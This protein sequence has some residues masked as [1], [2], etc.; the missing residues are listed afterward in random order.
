MGATG[1][2][3]FCPPSDC[4][5]AARRKLRNRRPIFPGAVPEPDT[6]LTEKV[7]ERVSEMRPTEEVSS[8]RRPDDL[9]PTLSLCSTTTI[10]G[11]VVH[12]RHERNPRSARGERRVVKMH[13]LSRKR[14]RGL[15]PAPPRRRF[16]LV[17]L[18]PRRSRVVQF[19]LP[20]FLPWQLRACA[21]GMKN[22]KGPSAPSLLFFPAARIIFRG[23]F[24]VGGG[25]F[26]LPFARALLLC[27]ATR[28]GLPRRWLTESGA[29]TFGPS[30]PSSSCP[31]PAAT[32]AAMS[33]YY[34]WIMAFV[35]S[36]HFARTSE[37]EGKDRREQLRLID[38]PLR[39]RMWPL[40]AFLPSFATRI[41]ISRLARSALTLSRELHTAPLLSSPLCAHSLE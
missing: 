21:V 5:T 25:V 16:L 28:P 40:H 20:S 10:V 32:A 37:E 27:V 9:L 36:L 1:E 19:P 12:E 23:K 2:A 26:A 11:S 31:P 41:T 24:G 35:R 38:R 3:L 39:C 33:S 8:R 22:E 6:A 7:T 14:E 29:I 18:P 30:P 13:S 15:E 4:A 17:F 34:G